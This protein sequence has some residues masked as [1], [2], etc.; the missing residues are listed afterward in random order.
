MCC[1]RKRNT[2]KEPVK[3]PSPTQTNVYIH[4]AITLVAL[5]EVNKK[6]KT[7]CTFKIIEMKTEIMVLNSI[8]KPSHAHS[9]T[10][11]LFINLFVA[12]IACITCTVEV[13]KVTH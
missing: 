9:T 7:T 2:I 13:Q 6:E 4:V 10:F 11:G 5:K 3:K 12:F 1:I 8:L